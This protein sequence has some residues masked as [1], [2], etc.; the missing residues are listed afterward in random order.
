MPLTAGC[1]VR[2]WMLPPGEYAWR[3]VGLGVALMASVFTGFDL[4]FT[5]YSVKMKDE[6]N[7]TQTEGRK[8]HY[9]VD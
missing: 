6:L 3:W 4:A 5:V 9:V 8:R 7:L 1:S 2:E